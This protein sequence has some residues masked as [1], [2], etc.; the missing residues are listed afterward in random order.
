MVDVRGPRPTSISGIKNAGFSESALRNRSGAVTKPARASTRKLGVVDRR[1]RHRRRPRRSNRARPV[2]SPPPQ[3]RPRR[4]PW[5]C[6]APR[7][8]WRASNQTEIPQGRLGSLP[9]GDR[10]ALDEKIELVIQFAGGSAGCRHRIRA[11]LDVEEIDTAPAYAKAVAIPIPI[12]PG[13]A[14]AMRWG[15]TLNIAD[16][17][18]DPRPASAS[19]P[20]DHSQPARDFRGYVR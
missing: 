4:W 17:R 3:G 2:G 15:S 9:G 6:R 1:A 13:P 19:G 5:R 8:R 11:L 16:P 12:R 20:G 14:T 10:R 7:P 18:R